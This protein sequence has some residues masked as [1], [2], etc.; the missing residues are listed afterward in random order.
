MP[1]RAVE[2]GWAAAR[3]QDGPAAPRQSADGMMV[4][5][6]QIMA[7]PIE[8]RSAG[9]SADY[10]DQ[11]ANVKLAASNL[12]RCAHQPAIAVLDA[13]DGG[14]IAIQAE[15]HHGAQP[16]VHTRSVAAAAA[17]RNNGRFRH[18][19]FFPRLSVVRTHSTHAH[20]S[21]NEGSLRLS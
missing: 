19:S 12:V 18:S 3:S 2:K 15:P 16:W 14:A 20:C 1:H 17:R 9:Q 6:E 4:E 10:L 13:E 21:R 8:R 7:A 11:A 5:P